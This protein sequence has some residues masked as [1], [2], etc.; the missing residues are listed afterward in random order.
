MYWQGKVKNDSCRFIIRKVDVAA[1]L[2]YY[3][4][5]NRKSIPVE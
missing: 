5:R 3:A 4:F 2:F 1:M